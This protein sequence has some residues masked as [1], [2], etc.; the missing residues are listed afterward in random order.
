MPQHQCGDKGTMSHTGCPS[1]PAQGRHRINRDEQIGGRHRGGEL[2]ERHLLCGR[3]ATPITSCK[4][5]AVD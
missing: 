1:A 3:V 5:A 2:V 4:P